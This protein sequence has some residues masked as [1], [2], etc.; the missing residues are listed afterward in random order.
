[1]TCLL[2][3]P[4]QRSWQFSEMNQIRNW[5][6]GLQRLTVSPVKP[7]SPQST[8]FVLTADTS[9]FLVFAISSR[10]LFQS[11]KLSFGAFLKWEL[12]WSSS[13]KIFSRSW[14]IFRGI[15]KR[16]TFSYNQDNNITDF[17]IFLNAIP[18]SVVE[19]PPLAEIT[20]ACLNHLSDWLSL[21]VLPSAALSPN[22]A[23]E[24]NL[25]FS[26]AVSAMISVHKTALFTSAI[27]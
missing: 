12:W 8:S 16:K 1:M 9:S 4:T 20:P 23:K 25:L 24:T 14:N 27:H 15:S 11:W 18:V 2:V 21:M 22:F 7:G 26:T 6:R 19:T 10:Y 13:L 17:E 5:I 3:D